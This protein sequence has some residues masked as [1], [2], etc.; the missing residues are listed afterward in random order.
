MVSCRLRR[1]VSVSLGLS[2]LLLVSGYASNARPLMPT[3]AVYLTEGAD[4]VFDEVPPKRQWT[5]LELFY[6]TDRAAETDPESGLPS[7]L[8]YAEG[9]SPALAFGDAVVEMAPALPWP[10]LVR[11]SLLAERSAKVTLALG[12]V[13]EAGRF[14]AEPDAMEHIAGGVRRS[15]AVMTAH[16]LSKR[17]FQT[18][19]QQHL[20]HS[21]RRQVMLFVHGFNETFATAAYTT[22]DLCHF[23]GREQACAF[24]TW[25]AA[26][27]GNLLTGYTAT[28]ESGEYAIGHLVKTI[29]L[30]ANTPGVEGLQLLAHSRGT[31]VMLSALRELAIQSIAAGYEPADILKI[32]NVVLMAPDIDA[33][34]AR[35]KLVTFSSDPDLIARWDQ[36]RLPKVL[37]GRL[38][39]Y[40]SPKDRALWVSKIL[41]GSSNR[42]GRLSP[43]D[44][45]PAAQ[46]NFSKWDNI[47]LIAYEGK[48]T[49]FF[50]HAYSS[51]N[52]QVS[53]DLVQ[54]IRYGR[55]PGE[56]GRELVPVG[57]KT[58]KFPEPTATA[59]RD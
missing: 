50:D 4:A 7:G 44:I 2:A 54:L 30:L 6:I 33:Q 45:S 57:A 48:I 31:A 51:S 40:T 8:P 39:I 32:D 22:A 38:T 11:Q 53:S 34:V 56:Q 47:D 10:E 59:T 3:P 19:L 29:R 1:L 20:A 17:E 27:S 14:P 9:R 55:A 5:R 43:E 12:T 23:F 37:N 52:P 42:L 15:R 46:D 18:A 16:E 28:T 49:D 35:A 24:F 25:P 58:W 41:F 36:E 13:K 26:S 21:P